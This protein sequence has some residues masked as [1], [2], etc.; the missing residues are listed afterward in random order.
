MSRN[1]HHTG[2]QDGFVHSKEKADIPHILRVA[3]KQLARIEREENS[4]WDT[5]PANKKSVQPWP[6]IK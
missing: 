2:F 3:T 4:T 6:T 5:H 1:F